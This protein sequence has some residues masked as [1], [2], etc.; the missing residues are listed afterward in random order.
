MIIHPLLRNEEY[1]L[2]KIPLLSF[3]IGFLVTVVG[4]TQCFTF[5]FYYTILISGALY[6]VLC[7]FGFIVVPLWSVTVS[8]TLRS[9]SVCLHLCAAA[10]HGGYSQ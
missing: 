9:V 6:H 10:E 7:S 1:M 8:L 2:G 4:N 5:Y 3:N